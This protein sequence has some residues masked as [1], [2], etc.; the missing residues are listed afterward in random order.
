[1]QLLVSVRDAAEAQAA[2]DG[3]ADWIDLKES[4][5]GPLGAVDAEVAREVVALANGRAAVSAACGELLDWPQSPARRL[6]AVDG[7][8]QLKLGLAGCRA[9]AWQDHWLVAQQEAADA[10]MGLVAVIY[11][12]AE[13]A[14]SP[15]P[16][17]IAEFAAAHGAK[18][19][20]VDTF[21]KAQGALGDYLHREELRALFA[22]ARA[23]GLT[24][25][26]AGRLT[27]AAIAA[28]PREVVDVAAVRSAACNGGERNAAISVSAVAALSKLV[29]AAT[30]M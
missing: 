17:E 28:L 13:L 6:L 19:L 21:D 27:A 23:Q 9:H 18:W 16:A 29:H 24:T 2:L 10:G 8:D 1:M 30:P 15:S 12:D 26:A 7:I 5:R 25:A 3:G 22:A 20:L 14:R 11:A 4:A